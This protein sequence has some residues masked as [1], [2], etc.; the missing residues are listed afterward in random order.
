MKNVSFSL[1]LRIIFFMISDTESSPCISST[2][3]LQN[4]GFWLIPGS[5]D[6]WKRHSSCRTIVFQKALV[7]HDF[8]L[9][10][11]LPI[12][13]EGVSK[14][15]FFPSYFGRLLELMYVFL[16]G[17]SYDLTACP[18]KF[19]TESFVRLCRLSWGTKNEMEVQE[20]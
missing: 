11:F 2:I 20:F 15:R 13:T 12:H 5:K 4:S 16:S 1:K 18:L 17:I 9:S 8:H 14:Q 10:I 19:L 6:F 7:L 3:I